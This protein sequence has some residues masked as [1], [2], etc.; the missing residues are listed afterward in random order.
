MNNSLINK[1]TRVVIIGFIAAC[2]VEIVSNFMQINLMNDYFVRELYSEE[3]FFVLAEKNDA[4][5]RFIGGL[6]AVFLFLS[7]FIIGRWFYVSAKTNQLYGVEKLRITPGWAVG[8]FFVPFANLVMPYRAL[9]EIYRASFK[10][11]DWEQNP[12]PYHFPIWWIFWIATNVLS[13]SSSRMG[14]ALGDSYTFTDLNEV[15]YVVI[16]SNVSAIVSAY[17]LLMIVNVVAKNQSENRSKATNDAISS[18]LNG[19]L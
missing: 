7:F 18:G 11:A 4:R 3:A 13:N 6:W 9:K 5:I 1:A 15:S 16:G 14:D 8:W 10:N 12:V 17:F 2:I 19:G